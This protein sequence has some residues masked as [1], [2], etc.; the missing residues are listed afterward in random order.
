MQLEQNLGMKGLGK[1]LNDP[2][3][4]LFSKAESTC[5]MTPLSEYSDTLM[6]GPGHI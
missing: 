5:E 1:V 2:Q 3:G 4:G 6:I